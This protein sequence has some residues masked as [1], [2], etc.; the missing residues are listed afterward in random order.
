MRLARTLATLRRTRARS[1]R[2]RNE[3]GPRLSTLSQLSATAG[4]GRDDNDD[5]DDDDDGGDD[6]NNDADTDADDGGTTSTSTST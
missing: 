1:A 3:N 4:P 2:R 5:D 6:D